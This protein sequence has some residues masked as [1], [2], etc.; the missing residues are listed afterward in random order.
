MRTAN[1][2][3]G[4]SSGAR[5]RRVV[6]ERSAWPRTP[7]GR[8]QTGPFVEDVIQ[9]VI[10][11]LEFYQST[12][13]RCADNA[14]AIMALCDAAEVLGRQDEGPGGPGVSKAPTES[15]PFTGPVKPSWSVKERC[16]FGAGIVLWSCGSSDCAGGGR[17]GSHVLCSR[18][19]VTALNRFVQRRNRQGA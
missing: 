1:P 14:K 13:F 7:T 19:S 3:G 2:A 5:V 17:S 15:D 4:V 18:P 11:R 12:K 16:L 8:S 10:G 6:A 9:A